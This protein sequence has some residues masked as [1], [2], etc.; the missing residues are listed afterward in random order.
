MNISPKLRLESSFVLPHFITLRSDCDDRSD[1]TNN[2]NSTAASST[3]A[4]GSNNNNNNNNGY[5]ETLLRLAKW[6]LED[7]E[8]RSSVFKANQA[9]RMVE[10]TLARM[11]GKKAASYVRP[12]D[13]SEDTIGPLGQWEKSAV[14]WLQ[15]VLDEEGR[16]AQQIV[17]Q[18]GRLI[19]P[20]DVVVVGDSD[21]DHVQSS[22]SSSSSSASSSSSPLGPLGQLEKAV[23]DW[24]RTIQWSEGERVRTQTLRPMDLE[25][26]VRGPLGQLEQVVSNFFRELRESE[27]LRLRLQQQQQRQGTGGGGGM[28]RP[29][30]VPGPMGELELWIGQMLRA[31]E[32]RA[33]EQQERRQ[34]LQQQLQ[35]QFQSMNQTTSIRNNSMDNNYA[36]PDGINNNI[37]KTNRAGLVVVRPKDAKIKG[38]LGEV[39]EKA[40]EFL[41]RLSAEEMERLRNM[42]QYL[43]E[44]RPMER[45]RQSFLGAVEAIVVGLIRAPLLLFNVINRVRELLFQ[46]QVLPVPTIHNSGES[47]NSTTTATE[48]FSFDPP[49]QPYQRPTNNSLKDD[50]EDDEEWLYDPGFQ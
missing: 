30:D 50:E 31:E 9:D 46:S 44:S 49:S 33:Q 19:R 21:K 27:M 2:N 11:T 39:E 12:M 14:T 13:A 40:F 10:E 26:S 29:I 6:S 48:A 42:E 22:T 7:Y 35:Q 34:H 1:N 37:L 47:S 41:D 4:A 25:E 28:V 38:P 36:E 3:A 16:R 32:L 5:R 15:Q 45:D 43:R 20:I 8:W 23:V 24:I 17:A 18:Q